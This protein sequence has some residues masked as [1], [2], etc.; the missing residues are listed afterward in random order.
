MK[1]PTSS[2]RS[3]LCRSLELR[4]RQVGV[5]VAPDDRLAGLRG[6]QEWEAADGVRVPSRRLVARSP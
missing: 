3:Q 4:L 2:I 1:M 6:Q 5:L